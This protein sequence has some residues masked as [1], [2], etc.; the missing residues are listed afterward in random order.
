[1][2]NSEAITAIKVSK[3][4]CKMAPNTRPIMPAIEP[5]HDDAASDQGE[6]RKVDGEPRNHGNEEDRENPQRPALGVLQRRCGPRAPA[7]STAIAGGRIDSRTIS[8]TLNTSAA[9]NQIGG[10]E[11]DIE[12]L[13]CA[14]KIERKPGKDFK[15]EQP[16]EEFSERRLAER[17]RIGLRDL[18]ENDESM[19]GDQNRRQQTPLRRAISPCRAAPAP[20]D[21]R[22]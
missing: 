17:H 18:I 9:T 3:T 15:R 8:P 5:R 4:V 10:G 11:R 1:M 16:A 14:K 21:G 6:D 12:T 20:P 19:D 22:E 13:Q 7:A 2:N